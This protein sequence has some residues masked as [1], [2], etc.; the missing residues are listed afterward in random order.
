MK[1][2]KEDQDINLLF[3]NAQQIKQHIIR[4]E[5]LVPLLEEELL[6]NMVKN[7]DLISL[8]FQVMRKHVKNWDEFDRALTDNLSNAGDI[9][10]R[11]EYLEPMIKSYFDS[12]NYNSLP[13]TTTFLAATNADA[14]SMF[15]HM[16]MNKVNDPNS[17]ID[18]SVPTWK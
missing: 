6:K 13:N 16:Y 17:V 12:F 18:K 8:Y 11:L 2:S 9:R 15:R 4:G 1:I 7:R 14:M 10:K 5:R 3:E